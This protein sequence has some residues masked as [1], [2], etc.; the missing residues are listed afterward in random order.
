[1]LD[2]FGFGVI[3]LDVLGR[4]SVINAAAASLMGPSCLYSDG[5]GVLRSSHTQL[6]A[7]LRTP[8]HG[9]GESVVRVESQSDQ[10]VTVWV[11]PAASENS[12]PKDG[13]HKS[14]F[15]MPGTPPALSVEV[16]ASMLWI[17]QAEARVVQA[18]L[19]GK[20]LM[21]C[22][23]ETG[24]AHNTV[25]NQLRSVLAKTGVGTQTELLLMTQR[26]VPPLRFA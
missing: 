4:A 14:V 20:S 17:T 15:I 16:L 23:R 5:T 25:R 8:A 24:L 21:E 1:M 6:D 22:A 11:M 3:L 10:P 18:L 9:S 19:A 2:C 7:V 12:A 13:V 26:L